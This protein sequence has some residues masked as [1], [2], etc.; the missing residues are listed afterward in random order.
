MLSQEEFKKIESE[1]GCGYWNL[2][3]EH[4]CPCAITTENKGLREDIYNGFIEENKKL[5]DEYGSLE[6]V[7][8]TKYERCR[9]CGDWEEENYMTDGM[10]SVCYHELQDALEEEY[11]FES[12]EDQ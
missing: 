12:E 7:E 2:C 10:C 9:E 3:W 8:L 6:D 4:A 5:T 1:H 11:Y